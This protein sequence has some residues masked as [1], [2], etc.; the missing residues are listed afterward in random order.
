MDGCLF[1]PSHTKKE[2]SIIQDASGL[3]TYQCFH[4]SCRDRTWHEARQK[5]SGN[6]N[7]AQFCKDYNHNARATHH[8]RKHP[9]TEAEEGTKSPEDASIKQVA[10]RLNDRINLNKQQEKIGE[11]TGFKFLDRSIYGLIKTF[12]YII[13]GYTSV[14]KSALLTQLTVNLLKHNPSIRVAVFSTEMAAEHILLRLMANRTVIPSMAIF[15]G[16]LDPDRQIAVDGAFNY[17]HNKSI[18]LFDDVYTFDGIQTKCKA[19]QNLDVVFVDFLQNLQAEGGIY[20]RMSVLPVQ[21][22]KMAKD[23]DTCVVAMSQVS[24]EAARGDP[25]IIGFKGAG[26]IAAASD[27]G[28]WLERDKNDDTLLHCYI[29]KNRHGPTGK[30]TLRYTNQFTRLEEVRQNEA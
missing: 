27:L 24:N 4:N 9:G 23:L 20:D 11:Q 17:F 16:K 15:T 13:G 30:A 5:I 21:L 10:F 14:G 22:Q 19:I 18:W 7:L 8:K 26:E 25:K 12:L 2:A 29:R 6:D 1:D 28:L 3:I